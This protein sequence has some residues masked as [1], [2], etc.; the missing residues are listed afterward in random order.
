MDEVVASARCADGA[1]HDALGPLGQDSRAGV[2][3]RVV[4]WT[5]GA[6]RRSH[7]TRSRFLSGLP[8]SHRTRSGLGRGAAMNDR[9]LRGAEN[10]RTFRARWA[11]AAFPITGVLAITLAVVVAI[12]DIGQTQRL[13]T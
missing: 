7:V 5:V 9:D 13:R 4:F 3:D 11:T 10:C 12:Y 1:A 2:P 8:E 6:V